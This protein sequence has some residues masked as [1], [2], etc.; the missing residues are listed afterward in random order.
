MVVGVISDTHGLVREEVLAGLVGVD[1][2]V[3]AGDIGSEDVLER[4]RAIAP[5]YAVRLRLRRSNES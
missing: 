3:H 4:L 1:L 5:T 2:I